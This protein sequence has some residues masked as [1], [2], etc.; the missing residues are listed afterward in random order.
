MLRVLSDD[1]VA[2][3]L[4][5]DALLPVV[6]DGFRAQAEGRVERPERPHFP[7]GHGL[8]PSDPGPAGTGLTMPAYVHGRPYY[9][10]KLAS[11]HEH[12]T[13]TVKAQVALTDAATGEPVAYLDGRRLTNARTGCVGGLAAR[14]HCGR[15]CGPV[16]VGVLGAGTQARWQARAIATAVDV[17]TLRVYSP[18]ASRT[19]C[20]AALRDA[21]LPAEAVDAPADAVTGADVVVTATTSRDPVFSGR[22]LADGALVVA[23]GAYT[24]E[25]RELD[26][27]TLARAARVF[28][29]VP[30]EAAETGDVLA[31]DLGPAAIEPFGD[32]LAGA[33]DWA[34]PGEVAVVLSVGSAVL[35]AVA[36]EHLY[37]RAVERD[38]G[39]VV[40]L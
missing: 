18:S 40:P 6:A 4:A 20:A 3:L 35:D 28:A 32:V 24:A 31:S 34:A 17:G 33:S 19:A 30:A 21:R 26:A 13:P 27:T 22:A 2:D 1:D 25:T 23:V 37:D 14:E 38:A 10:T 9:A 39:Q 11:V 12:A 15:E 29:D 36:A 7:V 16:R 8:A 5:L